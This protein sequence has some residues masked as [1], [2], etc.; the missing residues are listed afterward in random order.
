VQTKDEAAPHKTST[1]ISV[2]S[3]TF[4]AAPLTVRRERQEEEAWKRSVAIVGVAPKEGEDRPGAG[5][6][7]TAA[8]QEIH[9][10][11]RWQL[12][13]QTYHLPSGPAHIEYQIR[14]TKVN[15]VP[16]GLPK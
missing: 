5:T 14:D 8:V 4:P 13:I 6:D 11:E 3:F 2:R 10:A 12:Y 9:K 7:E 15:S 1:S 16:L